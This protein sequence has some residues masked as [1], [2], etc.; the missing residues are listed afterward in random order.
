[1]LVIVAISGRRG[2]AVLRNQRPRP[3]KNAELTWIT[4]AYTLRFRLYERVGA[5]MRLLEQSAEYPSERTIGDHSLRQRPG[6]TPA[7]TEPCTT[8]ALRPEVAQTIYLP[9]NRRGK[10][11]DGYVEPETINPAKHTFCHP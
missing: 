9:F 10:T 11:A 1:V 8:A 2:F 4:M 3:V 6:E 5:S 7:R